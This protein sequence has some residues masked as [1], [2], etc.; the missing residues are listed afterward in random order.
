[1]PTMQMPT[2]TITDKRVTGNSTAY[3]CAKNEILK[4]P[5]VEP[6]LLKLFNHCFEHSILPSIWTKALISPIPK[7]NMKNMYLSTS[8]HGLSLISTVAKLYSGLLN[9]RLNIWSKENKFIVN[10]QAGFRKGYSCMDLAFI[11]H[12]IINKT[13]VVLHDVGTYFS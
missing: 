8:Y 13:N 3:S 10:D 9:Q 6:L 7:G 2:T 1:M 11:L 4:M 12:N 5:G